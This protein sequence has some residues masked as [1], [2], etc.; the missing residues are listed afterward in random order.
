MDC[1]NNFSYVRRSYGKLRNSH[2]YQ[3]SNPSVCAPFRRTLNG[4]VEDDS[5]CS[6]T[7][8]GGYLLFLN[9]TCSEEE[10]ICEG[11]RNAYA[12]NKAGKCETSPRF[13]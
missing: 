10:V 9:G 6:S 7:R 11:A 13:P 4:H 5:D 8:S 1:E 3:K 2:A 12:F